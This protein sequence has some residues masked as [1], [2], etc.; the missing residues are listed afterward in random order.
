MSAELPPPEGLQHCQSQYTIGIE[1]SQALSSSLAVLV[2]RH[3]PD[4]HNPD[5]FIDERSPIHNNLPRSRQW[6]NNLH[7]RCEMYTSMAASA[8]TD[9]EPAHRCQS[10]IIRINNQSKPGPTISRALITCDMWIRTCSLYQ[11]QVVNLLYSRLVILS[12]RWV[13]ERNNASKM[14]TYDFS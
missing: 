10:R 14:D 13:Y 8:R 7:L 6:R 11:T 4:G 9:M 1:R 5:A 2:I 12:S 3:N